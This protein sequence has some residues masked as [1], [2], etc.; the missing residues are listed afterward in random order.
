M[1]D[2]PQSAHSLVQT[3]SY[4]QMFYARRALEAGISNRPETVSRTAHSQL[5]NCSSQSPHATRSEPARMNN[6]FYTSEAFEAGLSTRREARS[7]AAHLDL[8]HNRVDTQHDPN[9]LV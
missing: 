1:C 8:F 7:R 2:S 4:E 6:L 5:Q 3:C 9:L